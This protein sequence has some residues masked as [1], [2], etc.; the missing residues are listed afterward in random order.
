MEIDDYVRSI[1]GRGRRFTS[2]LTEQQQ[3]DGRIQK[4]TAW[5]R[6]VHEVVWFTN[7]T[8]L[9]GYKLVLC[10]KRSDAVARYLDSPECPP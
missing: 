4:D 1:E 6:T 5:P 10:H 3:V 9:K 7:E 8:G 2:L